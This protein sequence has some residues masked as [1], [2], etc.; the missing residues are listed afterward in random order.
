MKSN[1]LNLVAFVTGMLTLASI[2]SYAMKNMV[3]EG[4]RVGS[5]GGLVVCREADQS[6]RSV[7][8]LDYYEARTQRGFQLELSKLSGHWKAQT[9]QLIDRLQKVSPLR[10]QIYSD[11][12]KTV[13]A[14]ILF[15]ADAKFSTIPD[16]GHVAV[17]Q[18]CSFEQGAVQIAPRFQGDK[19]YFI[20]DD[21]WQKMNSSQRAGLIMHEFLYREAMSYGHTDSISVRYLSGYIA[22]D[23]FVKSVQP[24]DWRATLTQ[25]RYEMSDFALPKLNIKA[26]LRLND[27]WQTTPFGDIPNIV[28]QS[29]VPIL[30]GTCGGDGCSKFSTSAGGEILGE[31]GDTRITLHSMASKIEYEG[32]T[33]EMFGSNEYQSHSHFL[34]GLQN[35]K[36]INFIQA[37]DV[38][39]SEVVHHLFSLQAEHFSAIASQVHFIH[40]EGQTQIDGV[41]A[42]SFANDRLKLDANFCN[43]YSFSFKNKKINGVAFAPGLQP[44]FNL[45]G[46]NRCGNG[47][48]LLKVTYP[49]FQI[50]LDLKKSG[51]NLAFF[52][53]A[54]GDYTGNSSVYE[55]SF[56]H[57]NTFRCASNYQGC[58][59]EAAS[60][61]FNGKRFR[62]LETSPV[63]FALG[64]GPNS[65]KSIFLGAQEIE[66]YPNGI[67][68][69]VILKQSIQLV[70]SNGQPQSFSSS[71]TVYFN[72][73]GSV[74]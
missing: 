74:Q 2:N 69:S 1:R 61:P 51:H 59:I 11:W 64:I 54:T 53:E 41:L 52:D 60:G 56:N 70:L 46:N 31:N 20:N 6:I 68:K 67:P 12:L 63:I 34:M 8:L 47:P 26:T 44:E 73:D 17:P 58:M 10:V 32:N 57:K 71:S 22:N 55:M 13:D 16:T 42:Y 24:Y 25:A 21:L 7:E 18:G 62:I 72:E 38:Q 40:E 4:G 9:Q 28:L 33:L 35:H 5:G 66:V 29:S 37:R 15:L 3:L 30:L 27:L 48:S 36:T 65:E 19:R 49:T 43:A 39:A 23:R 14:E 45:L 50:D